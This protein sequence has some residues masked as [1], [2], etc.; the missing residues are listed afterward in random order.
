MKN[1]LLLTAI[2]LLAAPFAAR[3]QEVKVAYDPGVDFNKFKT[4][5]WVKGRPASSPQMHKL[6]VDEIDRQLQSKGL[7]KVEAGADLNVA[8]YASLDENINTGAVAYMKDSDWRKWGD[9]EP[10]YGPKMVAM[11]IARMVLDLVDAADGKLVWRG[12]A[13]DAYTPNQA[14]GKKRANKAMEKL[15]ADFPPPPR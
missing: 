15:F 6:I 8:Y 14:R 7:R 13:K 1:F 11:P 9:H 12:R 5:S 2:V 10:V 3:A 4:Y